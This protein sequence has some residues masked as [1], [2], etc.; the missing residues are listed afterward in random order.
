M[1][2]LIKLSRDELEKIIRKHLETTFK[3]D[4]AG[5]TYSN[6]DYYTRMDWSPDCD[7]SIM[8]SDQPFVGSDKP[9]EFDE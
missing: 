2:M 8:V 6:P 4:V 7:L 5:G 1:N 3:L 9:G